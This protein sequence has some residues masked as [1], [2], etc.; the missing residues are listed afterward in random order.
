MPGVTQHSKCQILDSN[1]DWPDPKPQA[2]V[3]SP[4][5]SPGHPGTGVNNPPLPPSSREE[6]GLFPKETLG[7]TKP[8]TE[9][10]AGMVPRPQQP[11]LGGCKSSLGR[12]GRGG[13]SLPDAAREGGIVPV[14]EYP[15]HARRFLYVGPEDSQGAYE[16]RNVI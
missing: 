15:P 8:K 14:T 10:R 13:C 9:N 4:H 6:A 12:A 16:V 2:L 3:A 11:N 1:L 7:N 5:G